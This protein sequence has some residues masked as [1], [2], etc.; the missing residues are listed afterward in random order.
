MPARL[1]RGTDHAA[2]LRAELR[3]SVTGDERR[4]HLAIVLIGEDPASERYVQNKVAAAIEIGVTIDVVRPVSPDEANEAIEFLAA[5]DEIDGI[6]LQMPAP[7]GYDSAALISRIPAAKDIDGLRP[8]SPFL[9][10][11]VAA[12]VEL[13]ERESISLDGQTVAV[14]GCYGMIGRALVR[15]LRSKGVTPLEAD[16]ETLDLGEVTRQ[17][18][19]L[20]STTGKAGLIT[21]DLVKED[22]ILIDVGFTLDAEGKIRGDIDPSVDAIASARSPV[23]GGIG[24][25]TVACLLKNLVTAVRPS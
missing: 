24:P 22:A 9:P 1:L 16:I 13:M 14:V 3:K 18:T 7:R 2:A 23:P 15:Y 10:A 21:A 19:L 11:T 5:D 6:V 8:D 25:L 20:F 4:P 12:I 17:A